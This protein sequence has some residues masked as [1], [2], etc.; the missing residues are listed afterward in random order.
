MNGIPVVPHAMDWYVDTDDWR[1]E[2]DAMLY[3]N[4]DYP[5]DD[6]EVEER[7]REAFEI[8]TSQKR[9]ESMFPD[10]YPID[11]EQQEQECAGSEPSF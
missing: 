3:S 2:K 10:G 1:I 11:S 4:S 7:L 5:D 8:Y 6:E 9:E